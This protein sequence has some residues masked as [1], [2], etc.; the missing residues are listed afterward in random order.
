MTTQEIARET[1]RVHQ[2]VEHLPDEVLLP[3]KRAANEL[4]CE[5]HGDD[6]AFAC[7]LC[8]ELHQRL[9]ARRG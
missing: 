2:F 8:S 3:A 9:E 1:S 7:I 4:R 5:A 6:Y